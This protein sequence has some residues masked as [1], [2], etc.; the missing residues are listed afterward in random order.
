MIAYAIANAIAWV[1]VSPN[2]SPMIGSIRSAIAGSPRNPIP[3]EASVIPTCEAA[4]YSSTCVIWWSASA[5]R[6][7]PSSASGSI[8]DFRDRTIANSAATKN[9]LTSTSTTTAPRRRTSVIG[10]PPGPQR[11]W[12]FEARRRRRRSRATVH[13]TNPSG[14]HHLADD[15]ARDPV[16]EAGRGRRQPVV[17]RALDEQRGGA[18]A[19]RRDR[20]RRVDSQAG[21]NRRGIHAE[22]ALLPE[23]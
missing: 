23:H 3:I 22:E 5:A 15:L 18:L 8:R 21:R 12:Y 13:S 6:R 11:G 9:P 16:P 19:D 17:G 14:L 2:T 7:S 1:P 4:T 20:E 10:T